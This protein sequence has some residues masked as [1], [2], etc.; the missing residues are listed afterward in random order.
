MKF[1]VTD[2]LTV[3]NA[4]MRRIDLVSKLAG[5]FAIA[6]VDAISTEV[7]IIVNLGMNVASVPLEYLFIAQVCH[8]TFIF[9][10][11]NVKYISMLFFVLIL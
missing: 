4:Q 6:M 2:I 7:A 9:D 3:M 8:W 11:R 1:G 5:P 10:K